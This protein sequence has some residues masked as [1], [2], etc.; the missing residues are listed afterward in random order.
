MP[1]RKPDALCG[2]IAALL[3]A[4]PLPVLAESQAQYGVLYR[5]GQPYYILL[6]SKDLNSPASASPESGKSDDIFFGTPADSESDAAPDTQAPAIKADRREVSAPEAPPMATSTPTA[7]STPLVKP[8]PVAPSFVIRDLVLDTKGGP[9]QQSGY[10]IEIEG[11]LK[12]FVDGNVYKAWKVKY[13][14]KGHARFVC[15]PPVLNVSFDKKDKK[16]N[17]RELFTGLST[18]PGKATLQYQKIRLVPVCD[19][20]EY[21]LSDASSGFAGKVDSLLREFVIFDSFRFFKIPTVDVIGFANVSFVSPDA[22][23]NGKKFRYM[24]LQRDN[25][26]DDELPFTRQFGL[27]PTLIE[28]GKFDKWR[29]QYEQSNPFT[30]VVVQDVIAKKDITIEVDPEIALKIYLLAELFQESDRGAL[31]NEDYGKEIGSNRWKTIP[32]GFDFSLYGCYPPAPLRLINEINRISPDK[33]KEY[34]A[35]YYRIAREIF[36]DSAS[37]ERMLQSVDRFPFSGEKDLL[38]EYLK[39]VFYHF[40]AYFGSQSFANY[41]GVPFV[42][43]AALPFASPEEYQ[44]AANAFS[45]RCGSNKAERVKQGDIKIAEAKLEVTQTD[46]LHAKFAIDITATDQELFIRKHGAF[47]GKLNS[48]LE[49]HNLDFQYARPQELE[50]SVGPYYN[51]PPDTKARF[52]LSAQRDG[53]YIEGGNYTA[54]LTNVALERGV[55]ALVPPENKTNEVSIV[56]N[57][58][59]ALVSTDK[60]EVPVNGVL[61]LIGRRLD[62]KSNTLVFIGYVNNVWT[63]KKIILP[64]ADGTTIALTPADYGLTAGW[65]NI[66]LDISYFNLGVMFLPAVSSISFQP[67]STNPPR[68]TISVGKRMTLGSFKVTPQVE[69]K[70]ESINV[71]NLR[72]KA[73]ITRGGILRFTVGRLQD[74][75][76]L[77]LYDGSGKLVSKGATDASGIVF[78]DAFTV[79][80]GA[81]ATDYTIRATLGYR[82]KQNQTI[83]LS[84]DFKDSV[85][86]IATQSNKP[87][88]A[89]QTPLTLSKMVIGTVA[90]SREDIV[91]LSNQTTPPPQTA[92]DRREVSTPE[93][94]ANPPSGT[95]STSISEKPY[96]R[97]CPDPT[98]IFT[99]ISY[100]YPGTGPGNS[101]R[102]ELVVDPVFEKKMQTERKV[103]ELPVTPIYDLVVRVV[104]TINEY[105]LP[106]YDDE[107]HLVKK[108]DPPKRMPFTAYFALKNEILLAGALELSGQETDNGQFVYEW[109]LKGWPNGIFI[110][111]KLERVIKAVQEKDPTLRIGVLVELPKQELKKE[112]NSISFDLCAPVS[113]G[114]PHKVVYMRGK[115]SMQDISQLF[116]REEAVRIYGFESIEPLRTYSGEGQGKRGRYF[117]H[118]IDLISHDDTKWDTLFGKFFVFANKEPRKISACGRDASQYFFQTG[119]IKVGTGYAPYG[120][121]IA[122]VSPVLTTISWIH[123]LGHSFSGLEDNYHT[124]FDLTLYFAN[125]AAPGREPHW[126]SVARSRA[127]GGDGFYYG[128]KVP[129][130]SV[131]GQ[132]RPSGENIMCGGKG[133]TKSIKS[134][135]Y[136][137]ASNE[138]N[139]GSSYSYSDTSSSNGFDVVSCGY[140][141]QAIKGG[142]ASLSSFDKDDLVANWEK[143]MKMSGVV[144]PS[145]LV[146]DQISQ[147]GQMASELL[148][149]VSSSLPPAND[150]SGETINFDFDSRFINV[151]T[152]LPNGEIKSEIFESN[153]DADNPVWSKVKVESDEVDSS[154]FFKTISITPPR[155][156]IAVGKGMT[157]GKFTAT[158]EGES[159]SVK[160]LHFKADITRG[161]MFR[162]RYGSLQ[163]ITD[164]GLYDGS[165]KLVS[166]GVKDASGIVFADAFTISS[167]T[168]Y[169]VRATLGSRFKQNQTIQLS[170]DFKDGII[171]TF[172]QTNKVIPIPTTPLTLS[173]MTVSSTVLK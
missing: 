30:K 99:G 76:E 20:N 35:L 135:N 125:C 73:D 154:I 145:I 89:P 115:S 149:G 158:A 51:I 56:G 159:I 139:V 102:I 41:T 15:D 60:K 40:G 80:A 132:S 138:F 162:F 110:S 128:D 91:A 124:G 90:P 66:R 94:E 144:K 171:F 87:V 32:Y 36:S 137:G 136:A 123:E 62:T 1:I 74:I 104:P 117:A 173:K 50:E 92:P 165:G 59:P 11:E 33:Q 21:Y 34:K 134:D 61:K 97:Y 55:A 42:P 75:T 28:D 24:L 109:H 167:T 63:T 112:E 108:V 169:T 78:A 96:A 153:G 95:P 29:V 10:N 38:K 103:G 147:A 31:H 46:N 107:G 100:Y 88:S 58:M 82:F 127:F 48:N 113:G 130:C 43:F 57:Q 83:Q 18:Y 6:P 14:K 19:P 77:G 64:S 5:D 111:E 52:L 84:T 131:R 164:I 142:T 8:I 53:R 150:S 9:V 114:S 93:G 26:K 54:S 72:F 47:S 81:T 44:S 49:S 13:E 25:E 17:P 148:A 122:F 67:I 163:D 105:C 69:T 3:M 37:L 118:L 157:L 166:K 143:C 140:L 156:T 12:E 126:G 79:P 2:T 22:Q 7:T 119:R 116:G 68:N 121:G 129:G 170:T 65:Y 172:T 27:E 86:F 16:G 160:N 168:D 98:Q 101:P 120:G 161:A 155:N 151:E 45:L 146:A 4:L 141:S 23:Y 39:L 133:C 85:V 71:K 106:Q 70:G 152:F